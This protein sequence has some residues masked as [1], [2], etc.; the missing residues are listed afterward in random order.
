MSRPDY[1][2]YNAGLVL[3][4]GG[5]KG[6]FTIGVLDFFMDK[7]IMF[8]DIYGVS[9]GACHM[10]SYISWQR[11][12]A[13][14]VCSDYLD[15]KNYVGPRSLL[16]TGDI[17]NSDFAYHLVPEYLNPFDYETYNSYPGKAY[18]VVTNIETGEPEY[19]QVTDAKSQIDYIRASASLPMVSRNVKIGDKL[20]LDGGISDAIPLRRSE[21]DG[22]RFNIVILTK[23]EGYVRTASSRAT[24]AAVKA[25]YL[26]Y[27]KEFELMR[28]R[29][30][31]YNREMEYIYER[32]AAGAA[33]IIR[34][35]HKSDVSRIDK[36]KDKLRAL[37][38]EG[39]RE[40]ERRY[41][42]ITEFLNKVK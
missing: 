29:D 27:P 24:L 17:F 13:L 34:P 33:L 40:A 7:G 20:Y 23:E 35:Q 18:A 30:I 22:N 3:E 31:R 1:K 2:I 42:A 28:N 14:D 41:P 8:S 9:A 4:G 36:D 12:R 5:M 25:R 19:L 16:T 38:E 10:T 32:Q 26:K 11:G 39:Y 37:Y 15:T 21:T 6:F